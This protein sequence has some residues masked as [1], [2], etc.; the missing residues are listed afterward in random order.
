MKGTKKIVG[1]SEEARI[2]G[3]E[4]GLRRNKQHTIFRKQ[5]KCERN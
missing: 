2:R 3:K 5:K 1:R 4:G